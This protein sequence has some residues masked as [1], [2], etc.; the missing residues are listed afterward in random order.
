[1]EDRSRRKDGREMK[2][3]KAHGEAGQRKF[4]GCGIPSEWL[5]RWE[6]T[7]YGISMTTRNS[8]RDCRGKYGGGQPAGGSGWMDLQSF[9]TVAFLQPL[10]TVV[11][12]LSSRVLFVS[13]LGFGI[14][15]GYPRV[16]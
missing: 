8:P 4:R 14:L 2:L 12:S 13:F 1:M 7:G 10:P 15:S 6:P 3:E 9:L 16:R 11:S 5:G